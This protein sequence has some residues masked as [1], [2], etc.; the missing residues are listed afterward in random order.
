MSRGRVS[1]NAERRIVSRD[2]HLMWRHNL[3]RKCSLWNSIIIIVFRTIAIK[4]FGQWNNKLLLMKFGNA[5]FLRC[6]LGLSQRRWYIF[7]SK[8]KKKKILHQLV[9]SNFQIHGFDGFNLGKNLL[10]NVPRDVWIYKN[11]E[12]KYVFTFSFF[13]VEWKL[14]RLSRRRC[15]RSL[16]F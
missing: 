14:D 11:F 5:I 7:R 13:T 3:A 10:S 9:N 2:M 1:T 16:T 12:K 8:F 4:F 15:W 6:I